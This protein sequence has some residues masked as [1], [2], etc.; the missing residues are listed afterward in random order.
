MQNL[1]AQMPVNQWPN[2]SYASLEKFLRKF[3][4]VDFKNL[5]NLKFL[6]TPLKEYRVPFSKIN[7]LTLERISLCRPGDGTSWLLYACVALESA[8]QKENGGV[9]GRSPKN[10]KSNLT[11]TLCEPI[12]QMPGPSYHGGGR[13]ERAGNNGGVEAVIPSRKKRTK[14]S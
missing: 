7:G 11:A 14:P 4:S 2:L 10:K 6:L 13:K 9:L 8:T 3:P 5:L 12:T 1:M